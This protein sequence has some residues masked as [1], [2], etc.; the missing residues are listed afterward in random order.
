MEDDFA[1]MGSPAR[2]TAEDMVRR[3][4]LDV[5]DDIMLGSRAKVGERAHAWLAGAESGTESEADFFRR[6]HAAID[7]IVQPTKT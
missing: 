5:L 1:P 3:A 4:I 7:A 2:L 6:A